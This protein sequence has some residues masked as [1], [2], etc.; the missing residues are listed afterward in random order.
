MRCVV[1]AL[2]KNEN[3]YINEW[4]HHYFDIGFK[5][6]YIF[7]NNDLDKPFIGDYID[8][9]IRNKVVIIDKKRILMEIIYLLPY[10]Y[11]YLNMLHHLQLF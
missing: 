10:I 11:H 7:D 8:K 2:A 3:L 4:C 6:I 1:C 9:T 5:K